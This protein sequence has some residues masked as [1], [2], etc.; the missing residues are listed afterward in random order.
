[1]PEPMAKFYFLQILYGIQYLHGK[2]IVYRDLKPENI[3]ID[4]DGNCKI[5]DFGL[6]KR[7]DPRAKTFSYCGSAEYMAPEMILRSGHSFAIDYYSLGALLYELVTGLPPYYTKNHDELQ[8]SIICKQIS[9]PPHVPL[10]SEIKDLLERLLKKEEKYRLGSYVGIKEILFHPWV[11]KVNAPAVLAKQLPPPHA[12]KLEDYNFDTSELGDDEQ[13]FTALVHEDINREAKKQT[14]YQEFYKSTLL[15]NYSN[16]ILNALFKSVSAQN[17][18]DTQ[19]SKDL[20]PK[21]EQKES[22]SKW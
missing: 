7:I 6:S 22:N 1:M 10:S 9:F 5:V 20:S 3:L 14:Y 8:E 12:P 21:K 17:R 18:E 13:E 19:P 16:P 11:G 2:S 4:A 15:T